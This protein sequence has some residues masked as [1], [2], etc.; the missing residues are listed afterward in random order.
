MAGQRPH[1]R[2]VIAATFPCSQTVADAVGGTAERQ[3]MLSVVSG[4]VLA[5]FLKIVTAF[6]FLLQ[7]FEG[8]DV[9]LTFFCV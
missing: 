5:R 7:L 6:F 8:C 4:A 3:G 2:W 1:P 9:L